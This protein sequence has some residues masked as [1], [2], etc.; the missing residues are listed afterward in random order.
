MTA[1]LSSKIFSLFSYFPSA[2]SKRTRV[3]LQRQIM[4]NYS[5]SYYGDSLS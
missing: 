3:L 4:A 2:F 1:F 5:Y